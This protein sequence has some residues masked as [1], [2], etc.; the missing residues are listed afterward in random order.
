MVFLITIGVS[1]IMFVNETG[2]IRKAI[3]GEQMKALKMQSFKAV[4]FQVLGMSVMAI[5]MLVLFLPSI[6]MLKDGPVDMDSLDYQSDLDGTYVTGTIYVVYDYYGDYLRGT[7]LL[8]REYIINAGKEDF[9]GMRVLKA[10]MEPAEK[11]MGA[12]ED[13][14]GNGGS[15]EAVLAAQY[16]VTGTIRKMPASSQRLYS[17]YL[18]TAGVDLEQRKH[19]LPYYLDVNAVGLTPPLAAFLFLIIAAVCLAVSLF[20]LVSFFSGRYQREIK[21][22]IANSPNPDTARER[23][24]EFLKST[25]HNYGLR[26]NQEFICG[27]W[28]ATTIFRETADVVWAY[29]K[30]VKRKKGLITV[31]R[32]HYLMVGFVNGSLCMID[33][34]DE[35]AA[36]AQVEKLAALCPRAITGYARELENLFFK[37]L[38][39]FLDI[40]YNKVQ[41]ANQVQETFNW[42]G[43]DS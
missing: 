6:K 34:K 31:M 24:E 29:P 20:M 35:R 32:S 43:Y 3:E 38:K 11:L 13:Y 7:Q 15:T 23:V 27:Q 18:S 39:G 26:C 19:F 5:V 14:L 25:A 28:G 12:Y 10:D 36:S 40:R 37:D 33:V 41:P 42:N 9:M 30:T 22:Y 17:Q 21:K 4:I 2:T 1:Y 8:S 16:E